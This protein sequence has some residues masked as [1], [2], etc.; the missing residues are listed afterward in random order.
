M[1]NRLGMDE[2][3]VI[4]DNISNGMSVAEALDGLNAREL[5]SAAFQI[6]YRFGLEDARTI[7]AYRILEEEVR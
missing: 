2:Y 1:K 7:K 5:E 4:L 6:G 3:A